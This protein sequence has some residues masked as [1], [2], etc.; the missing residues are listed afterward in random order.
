[1]EATKSIG[2]IQADL[3]YGYEM[4]SI[5]LIRQQVEEMRKEHKRCHPRW[6]D[7]STCLRSD[8]HRKHCDSCGGVTWPCPTLQ[9]AEDKLAL[10]EALGAAM[11]FL[12]VDVH[13]GPDSPGWENTVDLCERVLDECAKEE[14]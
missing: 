6:E 8:D 10:A 13:R 14:K 1:M 7:G 2:Q 12:P 9:L 4:T 5:E 3:L 11:Q